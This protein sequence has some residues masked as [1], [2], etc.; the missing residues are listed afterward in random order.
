[1]LPLLLFG[2]MKDDDRCCCHKL[3]VWYNMEET[4]NGEEVLLGLGWLLLLVLVGAI[5]CE[6]RVVVVQV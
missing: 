6:C 3:L 2:D 4:P 1:M 5:E